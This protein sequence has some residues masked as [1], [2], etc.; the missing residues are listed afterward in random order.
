ML[1]AAQEPDLQNLCL[2]V[3][4][5]VQDLQPHLLHVSV[6]GFGICAAGESMTLVSKLVIYLNADVI[7]CT[8]YL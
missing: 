6:D 7:L 5:G 2:G 3:M 1:A 4:H 8:F